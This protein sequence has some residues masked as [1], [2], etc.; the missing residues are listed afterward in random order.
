M[1]KQEETETCNSL[2]KVNKVC[3]F[4]S[5][6]MKAAFL[7]FCIWWLISS[8]FMTCSLIGIDLFFS[9]GNLSPIGLFLY[10]IDGVIIGAILL[11]LITI[12]SDAAHGISPFVMAQVKRLRKISLLLVSY[13]V[14]DLAISYNAAFLHYDGSVNTLNDPIMTINFS[15]VIAAAV[16]FAFSFV[17]KYGVLLQ[18]FSDETL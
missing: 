2:A 18:E 17:F 16:V 11:I 6:L 14:V 7:V 1:Y 9:V 15:P 8:I 13:T 4:L 10:I 5:L 3:K 12:F